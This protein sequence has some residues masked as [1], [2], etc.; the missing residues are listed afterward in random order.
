MTVSAS[1]LPYDTVTFAPIQESQV[2]REMITRY[3]HQMLD[4]ADT[5][6]IVVGAG[7]AGLMAAYE[8][9][10]DPSVR[11]AVIEAS[12]AP[13][14]GAWL[15]GQLMTAGVIR[16]PAHLILDELEVPYDDAGDNYVVVKHIGLLTSTLIAKIIKN[17]VT[18][19]NATAVEDL[20]VKDGEVKGVATNWALVTKAHGTQNCMDPNTLLSKVLVSV[21]GHDGPH[22][23]TGIKRL[24]QL[25]MVAD[26]PGMKALHMNSA[27]D[28][29]VANTKEIVP[30]FIIAGMEVSE[31]CGTNRMGATFGAM[32]MSGRK[33]GYLAREK[34]L[35]LRAEEKKL[36]GSH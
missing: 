30:G 24:H 1:T 12:V 16:K 33:A 22:G 20:I 10:K 9:S 14:G 2:A 8:A 26:V 5:D 34:V 21:C 35:K 28:A 32:I 27:E 18:L 15:G 23:A 6:V 4:A 36:A 29:I 17:G 13:G 7:P 19:F 11:V 31:A 25:G 3:M